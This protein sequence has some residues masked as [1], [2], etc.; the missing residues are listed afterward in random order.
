MPVTGTLTGRTFRLADRLGG[1]HMAQPEASWR[2]GAGRRFDYRNS[3][4]DADVV[5][6][7]P[8]LGPSAASSRCLYLIP[9]GTC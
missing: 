1:D 8:I 4:R 5:P 2:S 9:P 7:P 6:I 3:S